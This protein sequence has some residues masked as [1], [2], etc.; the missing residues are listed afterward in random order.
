[1]ASDRRI[2]LCW[3][4]LVLLVCDVGMTLAGQGPRY[5]R[6]DY[7]T[8][9]ELNPIAYPLLAL[10]PAAFVALAAAWGLALGVALL[11]CPRPLASVLAF[12]AFFGHAWGVAGWLACL[13]PP[14]YAAALGWLLACSRLL[15][16]SW[17]RAG[18][19]A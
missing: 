11:R 16:A 19:Q 3:P 8:A 14:G 9:V 4:P 1:M 17:R 2:W 15:T 6:G 10:H 5:W 13:G 7:G 18:I 12:A